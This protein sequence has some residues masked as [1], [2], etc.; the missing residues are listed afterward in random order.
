MILKKRGQVWIETVLYTLIGLA[1][2]G[3]VLAFVMPRVNQAKDKAVVDQT[4]D[5]LNKL[6]DKI[7][8]ITGAPG[9]VRQVEFTIK[10]GE[11]YFYTNEDKIVFMIKDLSAPYSQPGQSISIGRVRILSEKGQKYNTIT[12]TLDYS[13]DVNITF[14]RTESSTPKKF[15]QA[16]TPYKFYL[17]SYS[18]SGNK[19]EIDV[20]Q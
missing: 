12:L 4:I 10:R 17:T 9:N 11:L 1:L 6:D 3:V 20:S 16:P 14:Q 13:N 18:P 19:E 15:T 7:S 2:L 8:S 5:S